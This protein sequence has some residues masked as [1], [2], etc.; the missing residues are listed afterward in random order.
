MTQGCG[1]LSGRGWLHFEFQIAAIG[2]RCGLLSGR[3]WLHFNA[4]SSSNPA[5]ADCSRAGVGYT[6][7]TLNYHK[8]L[9]ADCSRAGVGYTR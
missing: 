8:V 6:L 3:G 5:V 1:L 7:A 4:A 2:T 9:V